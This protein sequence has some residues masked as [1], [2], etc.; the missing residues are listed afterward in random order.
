MKNIILFVSLFIIISINS[1]AQVDTSWVRRI[2]GPQNINDNAKIIKIAGNGSIYVGGLI[3]RNPGYTDA[4][5]I[6]YNQNG[7][8]AWTRYYNNPFNLGS[9]LYDMD[10]DKQGNVIITGGSG[11]NNYDDFF[12]VKFDSSGNELWAKRFNDGDIDVSH[13]LAIDDIG[14]VYVT[15]PSWVVNQ[16]YNFLT[17][18]YNP[19]GDSVW[20]YR[21]LGPET[22]ADI[23]KDIALDKNGNVIVAGTSDYYWGTVDYVIIK[24]DPA[25]DTTWVI[26]YDSPEQGHDYL[27]A[28]GA[29]G[30]GNIYV[31]GD[32][33]KSGGNHDIITIKYNTNGDTLWT[34][35]YNGLG[36]GD[37]IVNAMAVDSLGNIY[38]TG[39]GFVPSKGIDCLTMKYNSSGE[40]QWAKTYAG[41]S[42]YPDN[43]FSLALD[44]S[45]NV[46][47][48][49]TSSISSQNLAFITIK[50]DSGGNQK[51]VAT[52]D[53]PADNGYDFANSIC[54]DN[55]G[56]V[57]I[58]GGSVG[59]TTGNDITTI[60]YVQTPT[61]IEEPSAGSPLKYALGQ[62][63]P[64]PF[65]PLTIINYQLPIDNWVSLKVYDI[66]G[67]EVATLVN[68]YKKTGRYDVE[69]SAEGGSASGR[70]ASTLSSGVYLYRLLARDYVSTKKFILL[71]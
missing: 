62:N 26:K 6:K 28:V 43:A 65:N 66:L 33:Y 19:D 1:I 36:N 30:T 25:R 57:F 23:P 71:K 20:G 12:T 32:S 55:S 10:V 56:N 47:I 44:K 63:Y 22:A 2:N 61:S 51:W 48:T 27:K 29:D 41:Y 9:T 7:D 16:S 59:S 3:S 52:Y 45:G 69:F 60:K 58:T 50:Y 68:E 5:V 49:G 17:I 4:I 34:R 13:A 53:G 18:K 67:Q 38:L 8:T 42:Y 46:Y 54:V 37:D 11:G 21:F 31:T 39:N 64:N 14:N 40:L 35:R 24:I 70:N 15:G